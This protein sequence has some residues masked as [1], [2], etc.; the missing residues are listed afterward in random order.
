LKE[1]KAV[2]KDKGKRIKVKGKREEEKSKKRDTLHAARITKRGRK[3]KFRPEI[4]RVKL[5]PEQAVLTCECFSGNGKLIMGRSYGT[6]GLHVVCKNLGYDRMTQFAYDCT[7]RDIAAECH[8][9]GSVSS[10]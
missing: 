9:H 5:N 8:W 2:V 4:T 1:I 3:M 7:T 6:G 10:S